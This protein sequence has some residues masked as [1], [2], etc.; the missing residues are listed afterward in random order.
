MMI[1]MKGTDAG[2]FGTI[3]EGKSGAVAKIEGSHGGTHSYSLEERTTFAKM[4]N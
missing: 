2:K 3:V 4:V 1:K